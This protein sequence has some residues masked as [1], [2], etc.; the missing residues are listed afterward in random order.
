LRELILHLSLG[1]Q[2]DESFGLVKLN[3]LLFF[4]DFSA[5]RKFGR[6]ITGQQYLAQEWG[7]CPRRMKPVSDAMQ[8]S[9]QLAIQKRAYYGHEQRRPVALREA[10]LSGFAAE[11]IALSD[12]WVQR[13]WGTGGRQISDVSHG[14]IGWEIAEI[15]DPI[16]YSMA[17]VSGRQPT[18][19]ERRR[20]LAFEESARACLAADTA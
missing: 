19:A 18:L 7:P 4:C 1:S 17:L 10:D 15:G 14:F 5:Y 3:K 16:P 11:E 12:E 13:L 8:N 20:G 2:A 6:S 9:G